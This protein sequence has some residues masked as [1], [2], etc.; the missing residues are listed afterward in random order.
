M[1]VSTT[2]SG[3]SDVT[4]AYIAVA[5]ALIAFAFAA[6]F[7]KLSQD[8]GLPSLLIANG[9]LTIATLILTPLVLSRYMDQLRQL[10]RNDLLWAMGA[11]FWQGTY[12]ILMTLSLEYT[13]VLINQVLVNTS[14]LWVALMEMWF[15]RAHLSRKVWLGL[16]L[17]LTG[18][19][20]IAASSVIGASE[21]QI[22]AGENPLFGALLALVGAIA[23]GLYLVIG[24]KVRAKVAAVPYV[25]MVYGAGSITTFIV[26]LI[27]NTP[28]FGHPTMGYVWLL[29]LALIPQIV[30]HSGYNFALGHLPAT[31][32]SIMGQMATVLSAI[33]AFFLLS[34]SPQL[35][36]VV[37]SG[38]IIAGVTI[39]ILNQSNQRKSDQEPE[40]TPK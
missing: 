40:A 13:S 9:R 3:S 33:V 18:G 20:F 19:T 28:I 27:T 11:G 22:S 31:L 16:I 35:L 4:K 37:G 6:N 5:L 14:P 21:A 10:N 29:M 39:A 8:G 30:G 7:T 17:T 24:R 12:F 26:I 1:A 15:L 23:L 38:I 34:E 2:Q 36:E 25:W 32:I